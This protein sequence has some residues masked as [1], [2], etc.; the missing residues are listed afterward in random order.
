MDKCDAVQNT[1]SLH[2]YIAAIIWLCE[3]LGD[4]RLEWRNNTIFKQVVKSL[5][6]TYADEPDIRLPFKITHIITY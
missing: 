3:C 2:V 6:R 1:K 4:S 5:E